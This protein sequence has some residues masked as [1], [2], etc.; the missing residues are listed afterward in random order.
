VAGDGETGRRAGRSPGARQAGY[1]G[2]RAASCPGGPEARR[3]GTG[4]QALGDTPPG[5]GMNTNASRWR[6]QSAV[7]SKQSISKQWQSPPHI[8]L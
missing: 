7:Q 6:P 2:G 5:V 3:R 8:I 4:N 1:R